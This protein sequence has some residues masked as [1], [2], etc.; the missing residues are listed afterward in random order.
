LGLVLS[1]FSG[2]EAETLFTTATDFY[3]EAEYKVLICKTHKQAVK[4]LD[5]YP[6]DAH[7]LSKRKERRLLFDY[8]A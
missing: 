1:G 4:S 2:T 6:R 3:Y 5:G 8:Y 7:Q